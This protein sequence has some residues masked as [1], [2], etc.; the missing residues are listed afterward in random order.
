MSKTERAVLLVLA[1]VNF[2]HIMDVMIIMPLG[3][4]FMNTFKIKPAQF[5]YLVSAYA[6][7][8]F[9]SSMISVFLLD[10]FDRKK[11]LL[12][13][14][15]GFTIGTFL[16]GLANSYLLLISMRFVTGLFGGV[17]GAL[18]LSIISDVFSYE[19]RG[20][21]IGVLMAG[22]SAAAALGVPFGLLLSEYF[23]WNAPFICIGSIGIILITLIAVRFPRFV[24]HLHREGPFPF[25]RVITNIVY[26]RNQLSAL[27]LGMILVLGHYMIIPFI[28]PYMTRNVGFSQT[29]IIYIYFL[30]GIFTVFSAPLIGRLT[31]RFS[32]FPTFVVTMGLSFV[33]VIWITNM[34]PTPVPVALIAT[35][36]LFVLGSGRLI[37]PQTMITAAVGPHSRGSFM[38][39][40]SALQQ[41]SIALA[42]LIS[43]AI[44]VLG[45]EGSLQN[46]P[47]VGY[48]SILLCLVAV[49]IAPILKVAPGN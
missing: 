41:L 45:N 17:I 22:F 35:S 11:A 32:P 26:D 46:Y 33:P 25:V 34:S 13:V 14:Y 9:V 5:S 40:K 12:F 47:F 39:I 21:A 6:V 16:C 42:S 38:S 29:E 31:D 8:A 37:A 49:M 1:C 24:N 44:I 18:A 2:T 4:V 23:S 28:A 19:R 3:D 36:L 7:G 43:G 10:R 27:L 20:A 48:L 15:T 30:G